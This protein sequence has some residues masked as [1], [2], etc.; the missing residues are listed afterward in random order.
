MTDVT[1]DD[2]VLACT[3]CGKNQN[4]VFQLVVGPDAIHCI[5]NEC[6]SQCVV[7]INDKID[8]LKIPSLRGH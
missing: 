2:K 7:V 3:F 1:N 5:C 8:L 6:V 4:E